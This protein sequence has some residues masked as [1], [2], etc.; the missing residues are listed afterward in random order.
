MNS[1]VIEERKESL[2]KY[3][4]ELA[5]VV[6]IFGDPDVRSFIAMKDNEFMWKHFKNLYD[7]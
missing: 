4:N 5:Q 1:E 7:Y 3:M 6:N 2:S